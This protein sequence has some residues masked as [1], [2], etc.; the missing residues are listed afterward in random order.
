MVIARG[1]F[2]ELVMIY[3]A[4]AFVILIY[5]APVAAEAQ[6]LAFP[7][8]EGFGRFATGA[9]TNLAAA[10]VYHVANL[11]D[12]GPGS[13]RD[14]VSQPNR[15]V[16]FDVGGIININSVVPVASNI[17][18]AGQT[19]PGGIALLQPDQPLLSRSQRQRRSPRGCG[20]HCPRVE[21]DFR[22]HVD[23]LGRRWHL[24]H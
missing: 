2:Q 24:R 16:V 13:F 3:A 20:Q 1:Q 7:E 14:A 4:R 12:S 9:R 11:N 19:A 10:N 18:I 17:T 23:H 22:P 15:F 5:L 8:A 21:H 6:V